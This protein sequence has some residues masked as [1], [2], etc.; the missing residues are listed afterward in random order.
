MSVSVSPPAS[1]A[2]RVEAK[3]SRLPLAARYSGLMPRRSRA[4][5]RRPVSRSKIAKANMPFR[6]FTQSAPQAA[7]ALRTTSVSP[8]E[9]NR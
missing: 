9:K 5:V 1:K 7:K 6:R 8:V 4:K 3:R 2:G